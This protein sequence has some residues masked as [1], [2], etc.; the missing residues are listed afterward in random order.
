MDATEIKKEL[1]IELDYAKT[2]HKDYVD[3]VSVE[4]LQNITDLISKQ[5]ERINY[6]RERSQR[7][8]ETLIKLNDSMR[9]VNAALSKLNDELLNDQ[10][11]TKIETLIEV[12]ERCVENFVGKKLISAADI[13]K[14]IKEVENDEQQ[15]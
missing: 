13:D 5:E 3:C 2:A 11:Q 10:K 14:L 8:L 7:D 4:L 6:L 9:N 12:K 1:N 15:R